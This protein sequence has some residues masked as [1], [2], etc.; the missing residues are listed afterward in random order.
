MVSY[1]NRGRGEDFRVC[2]PGSPMQNILI[3]D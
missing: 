3:N 2:I 1:L